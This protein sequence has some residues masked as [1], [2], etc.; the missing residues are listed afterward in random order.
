[1]DNSEAPD[2]VHGLETELKLPA[3]LTGPQL[4][5]LCFAVTGIMRRSHTEMGSCGTL[6]FRNSLQ[7]CSVLHPCLLPSHLQP[8]RTITS[9]WMLRGRAV[10]KNCSF[11]LCLPTM[12]YPH[13]DVYPHCSSLI[14][15]ECE[16]WVIC[17]FL[18][19]A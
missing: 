2:I 9:P 17:S 4:F 1:M 6:P 13:Y 11:L 14:L 18:S 3:C 15:G 10:T 7:L 5:C 12:L 19:K 8:H 16:A